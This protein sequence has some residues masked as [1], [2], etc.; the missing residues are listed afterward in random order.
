[1]VALSVAG[2][3]LPGSAHAYLDPGTGSFIVQMLVAGFL[4][5]LFYIKMTWQRLKLFAARLMGRPTGASPVANIDTSSEH[6]DG[7]GGP[8][9]K[10]Q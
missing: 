6:M 9:P 10:Q 3:L 4:G 5:A 8:G 2:A 1:M 7:T